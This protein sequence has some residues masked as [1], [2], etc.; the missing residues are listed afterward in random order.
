MVAALMV[1]FNDR[2]PEEVHYVDVDWA[3]TKDTLK[4]GEVKAGRSRVSVMARNQ[5]EATLLAQQM[6]AARGKEPTG[7]KW[8]KV[9]I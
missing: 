5:S 4:T 9:R 6:V 3:H 2:R 8:V 1:E 7:A